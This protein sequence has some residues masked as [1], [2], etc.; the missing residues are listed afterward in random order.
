MIKKMLRRPWTGSRTSH[1]HAV[2]SATD[3]R[4]M[5]ANDPKRTSQ[6]HSITSS[7]ICWRCTGTLSPNALRG[8]EVDN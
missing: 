5:S 3:M 8:P 1:R 2:M 4:F 7:A 6:S